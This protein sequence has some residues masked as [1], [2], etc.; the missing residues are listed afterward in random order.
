MKTVFLSLCLLVLTA[1]AGLTFQQKVAA[2]CTTLGGSLQVLAVAN[3]AG[4]I[5]ASTEARITEAKRLTDPVCKADAAPTPDQLKAQAFQNAIAELSALAARY[6][7]T[8]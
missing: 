4:K 1:C 6:E 3:N 7:V 8:P 5:D 2:T